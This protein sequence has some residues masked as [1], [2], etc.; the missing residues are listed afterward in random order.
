MGTG[1]IGRIL[2]VDLSVGMVTHSV[3]GRAQTQHLRTAA[4]TVRVS[5]KSDF[6]A[7]M[8]PVSQSVK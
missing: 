8:V 4:I 1:Q 7:I 5:L 3:T 2:S 6:R